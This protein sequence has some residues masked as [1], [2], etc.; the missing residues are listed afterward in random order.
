MISPR[1]NI[2]YCCKQT[3]HRTLKSYTTHDYAAVQI[4][5]NLQDKSITIVILSYSLG[6]NDNINYRFNESLISTH[7]VK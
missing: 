7:E 6:F 3:L 2:R 1:Q 4:I 5:N